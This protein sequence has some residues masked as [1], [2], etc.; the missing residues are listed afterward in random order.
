M[1]VGGSGSSS[2]AAR[3]ADEEAI[4]A[5]PGTLAETMQ[6]GLF[7][8]VLVLWYFRFLFEEWSFNLAI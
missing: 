3:V 5:E 7:Y 6:V 4:T 8:E 2:T 1:V